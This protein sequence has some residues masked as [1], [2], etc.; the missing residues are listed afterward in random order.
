MKTINEDTL[1]YLDNG[2]LLDMYEHFGAHLIKDNGNVVATR[3]TVYAPNAKHVKVIGEFNDYDEFKHP[4]EKIDDNGVFR[5]IIEQ[6]LSRLPYKYVIE[7]PSGEKLYK[8]DPFAY[9]AASRPDTVSIVSDRN[10]YT[11]QDHAYMESRKHQPPYEAPMNI[12]ELHVGTW[13]QRPNGAFHTFADLVE[14][15]IPY[16]KKNYYTHV[17]L[18]PIIEHPFDGSW[19]YQGT[20]YFAI[21]SRYGTVDDFKYF[22]DQCHQNNIKVLLDWV[23]G[24]FCKDAHGLHR[25]DG[26]P[27]FEYSDPA[28][29]ENPEWGTVN[30]D[31]GKGFTRS[32]LISSALFFLKE[33]HLDGFR[34][35][36]VSYMLYYHGNPEQGEN[37]GAQEFLK[38]L[39]YHV[40]DTHPHALMI[41]EDSSAYPKV[42]HPTNMGGLGFNYKWN[43]G[44]M[45]DTLKY[46]SKDPIH[47]KY[48]HDLLTFSLMYAFSENY[49]LPFSHDEVVHGKKSLV[50]KMPGDYWQKF[51]NYRALMGYFHTHPGKTLLFMGQEFAQMHEWKDYT[52]LDWHLL[53]YPMHE[54]AYRF[55]R[56]MNRLSTQEKA[57]YELDH[58]PEGFEWIDADNHDQ[59]IISFI[60]YAKDKDDHIVVVINM[61]PEVHH[62]FT[63]GVPY[64]GTYQ[65]IIN[66]DYSTYGGSNLYNGT[67][68]YTKEQ[69]YKNFEQ[70]M[71]ILVS[72]LSI[73][74]FKWVKK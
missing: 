28:I 63:I 47:R 23:P 39:S 16:L 5:I 33:Y 74:M 57:L 56:E 26:S 17:E 43:M 25:F 48:H 67:D 27:L 32:F 54:S 12:Y 2:Q 50:D 3:F 20:G 19:G 73:A 11:W 71:D 18:M 52:E 31:L 6:D 70:S 45:N 22:V 13:M 21:T 34:I 41:A 66:S 58:S 24:H 44:W 8:T 55:N 61:T 14:Y 64:K 72:P 7:T 40:F 15:L 42:T 69:S 59:S 60:R 49:V 62:H 51:A 65:E 1:Y 10:L 53:S 38:S 30:F 35:D 68:I 4:L 46:F 37:M 36:A 9:Y 29:A